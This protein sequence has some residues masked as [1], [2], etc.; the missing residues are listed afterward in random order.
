MLALIALGAS[1]YALPI[2]SPGVAFVCFETSSTTKYVYGYNTE[3]VHGTTPKC[4]PLQLA[5]TIFWYD[6]AAAAAAAY[7]DDG[8]DDTTDL[9]GKF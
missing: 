5:G 1:Y 4:Y 9:F 6:D 7:D 8:P 2:W 3:V